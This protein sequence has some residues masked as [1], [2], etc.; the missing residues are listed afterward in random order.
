MKNFNGLRMLMMIVL[1][2]SGAHVCMLQCMQ[3]LHSNVEMIQDVQQVILKCSQVSIR[4]IAAK[5]EIRCKSAHC[6][7]H[8]PNFNRRFRT[9]NYVVLLPLMHVRHLKT[10]CCNSWKLAKSMTETFGSLMKRTF[11]WTASSISKTGTFGE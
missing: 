7:M 3:G 4:R 2:K 11:P 10:L 9:A 6:I 5:I 8:T 1:E